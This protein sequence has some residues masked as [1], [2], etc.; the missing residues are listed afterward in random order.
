MSTDQAPQ[1]HVRDSPKVDQPNMA[2]TTM[3]RMMK[4]MVPEPAS[5][6]SL[7]TSMATVSGITQ[8]PSTHRLW[9]KELHRG[10]ATG[11]QQSGQNSVHRSV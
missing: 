9:K 5:S 1:A 7:H 4:L 8:Y 10:T 11:K 6:T 3:R 2:P